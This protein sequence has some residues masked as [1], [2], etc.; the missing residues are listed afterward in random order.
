[1]DNTKEN[2]KWKSIEY[3]IQTPYLYDNSTKYTIPTAF[4]AIQHSKIVWRY[5]K[6]NN[7]PN[8]NIF[9]RQVTP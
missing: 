7:D 8:S 2:T 1:V 6:N 9:I 3:V 4:D 5:V